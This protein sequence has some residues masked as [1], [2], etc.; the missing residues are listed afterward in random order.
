MLKT[1][2]ID[3]T[4]QQQKYNV[5]SGRRQVLEVVI[6]AYFLII[7]KKKK[8]KSRHKFLLVQLADACC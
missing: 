1:T 6:L 8:K 5:E 7:I 2:H 3:F 4:K